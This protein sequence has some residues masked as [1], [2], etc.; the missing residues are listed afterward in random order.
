M[1]RNIFG[2]QAPKPDYALIRATTADENGN[3]SMEDEGIRRIGHKKQQKLDQIKERL[4]SG[5]TVDEVFHN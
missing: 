3:L 5:E 4:C 2:Y 1:T